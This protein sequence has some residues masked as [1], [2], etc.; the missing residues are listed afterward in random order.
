M[1]PE[2]DVNLRSVA[3]GFAGVWPSRT[4]ASLPRTQLEPAPLGAAGAPQDQVDRDH[5]VLQERDTMWPLPGGGCSPRFIL[6]LNAQSKRRSTSFGLCHYPLPPRP[7][8]CG[9]APEQRNLKNVPE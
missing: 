2:Q 5:T 9:S 3:V 1:K 6:L 8:K 4:P 7:L